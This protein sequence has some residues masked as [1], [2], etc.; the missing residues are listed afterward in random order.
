MPMAKRKKQLPI[1]AVLFSYVGSDQDFNKFLK[2]V[3]HDYLSV[4]D[5]SAITTDKSISN[6][7]KSVQNQL[8]VAF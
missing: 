7:E 3:V 1:G 4:S 8:S 5:L 2:S 6:V